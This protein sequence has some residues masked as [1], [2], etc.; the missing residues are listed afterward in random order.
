MLTALGQV[1][2]ANTDD[3]KDLVLKFYDEF[4]STERVSHTTRLLGKTA[5]ARQNILGPL[6]LHVEDRPLECKAKVLQMPKVNFAGMPAQVRDGSWN[7]V[8]AKF[9][10]AAEM[11]SFAV[12]NL[13][14]GNAKYS[15]NAEDIMEGVFEALRGH[16]V[17]LPNNLVRSPVVPH[18]LARGHV[19]ERRMPDQVGCDVVCVSTSE[20]ACCA[21]I[22]N[23]SCTAL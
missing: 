6:Q 4:G 8:D 9:K 13:T 11:N 18:V 15:V 20:L 10:K 3:H 1:H 14:V 2:G 5:E 22:S 16:N 7:L 19:D 23:F 21:D 12:V 17:R